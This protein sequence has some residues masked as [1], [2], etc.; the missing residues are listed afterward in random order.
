VKRLVLC[1]VTSVIISPGYAAPPSKARDKIASVHYLV[2]DWNC[3]H[4]VGTFAGTYRTHYE[5]VLDN[6]WLKQT[7]DFPATKTEP[8]KHAETLLGYD[9]RR[10]AWVRFFAMNDGEYFANRMTET[11]DGW[12]WKYI[13]FFKN[14]KPESPDPDATFTKTSDSEYKVDGPSYPQDGTIVTEHHVCKKL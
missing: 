13:S 6:V 7:T 2:G 10:A 9:E 5:P 3:E 14:Q 11:A 8:A 12:S 1:A 4:T